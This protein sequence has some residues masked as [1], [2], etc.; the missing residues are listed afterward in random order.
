MFVFYPGAKAMF[1][2]KV[3]YV[4]IFL[5]INIRMTCFLMY[6]IAHGLLDR[7]NYEFAL[8]KCIHLTYI[9]NSIIVYVLNFR[10]HTFCLMDFSL[11]RINIHVH[12][13]FIGCSDTSMGEMF[14][15]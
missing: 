4:Y 7:F 1:Y 12:K 14:V 13:S 9:T 2:F 3:I 11:F 15:L 6:K 8:F 5:L 10:L